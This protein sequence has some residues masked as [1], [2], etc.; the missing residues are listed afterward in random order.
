MLHPLLQLLY[1]CFAWSFILLHLHKF[2]HDCATI[3]CCNTIFKKREIFPL[4]RVR[5]SEH[6]IT[7]WSSQ[8]GRYCRQTTFGSK[9][10]TPHISSICTRQAHAYNCLRWGWRHLESVCYWQSTEPSSL[11][12]EGSGLVRNVGNTNPVIQRHIPEDLQP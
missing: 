1:E 5:N 9:S 11:K 3:M 2:M 10:L 6:K 4:S 8:S 12:D 7:T